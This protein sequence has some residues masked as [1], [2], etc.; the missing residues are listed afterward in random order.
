MVGRTITL[1]IKTDHF[2]SLQRSKSLPYAVRDFDSLYHVATDLLKTELQAHHQKLSLRLM[3]V[4]LSNLEIR[5]VSKKRAVSSASSSRH[6]VADPDVGVAESASDPQTDF[7]RIGVSDAN[8]GP[9]D[10]PFAREANSSGIALDTNIDDDESMCDHELETSFDDTALDSLLADT[11]HAENSSAASRL[12]SVVLDESKMKLATTATSTTAAT[13]TTLTTTTFPKTA[14]L[15]FI[16]C[17]V[18]GKR[19]KSFVDN[20]AL[21]RHIDYCLNREAVA[22]ATSL[23]EDSSCQHA[24]HQTVASSSKSTSPVQKK[25]QKQKQSDA[26][27]SEKV[28]ILSFFARKM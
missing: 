6:T 16:C 19:D 20:D 24:P 28:D 13:P 26:G 27:S 7:D 8:P 17:P 10:K 21:N 2:D 1:K 3:G 25:K 12:T 18:C 22:S 23:A 15:V 5:R 14:D 4:R 9:H 11:V